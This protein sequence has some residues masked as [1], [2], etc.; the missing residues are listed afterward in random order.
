MWKNSLKKNG[1]AKKHFLDTLHGKIIYSVLCVI[2]T[3]AGG[4]LIAGD[5]MLSRLNHVSLSDPKSKVSY[6]DVASADSETFSIERNDAIL[7]S[8]DVLNILLI[9]SDT[10]SNLSDGEY[11]NSDSM[12]LFSVNKKTNKL[13]MV[14]F[15]RDLYVSIDG[16]KSKSRIN[17]AFSIGGPELLINTI[18]KNFGVKIDKYACI[19][20]EGFEKAIDYVG[21]VTVNLTHEEVKEL[22][23]NPGRYYLQVKGSPQKVTVGTNKLNGCTALA[24]ARIRHIDSDFYRTQRQRNVITSLMSSLKNSNPF[25]L[26]NIANEVF[27]L[28]QTDLTND[29]ILQLGVV[30]GPALM[31][32]EAEQLTIPATGAYTDYETPKNEKVLLPDLEKN[33]EIVQ[34]FLY[35]DDE[36]D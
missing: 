34:D 16:F 29:Q 18:E 7:G 21:G 20:F 35:G 31:A 25:T 14:S 1:P 28:I 26:M 22:T 4:A 13:K 24:Y 36:E 32:G 8:S 11:G 2:V 23:K 5:V 19:D 15:L 30:R 10:R 12:I 6:V 9:G 3:I 27:P 33:R 17:A